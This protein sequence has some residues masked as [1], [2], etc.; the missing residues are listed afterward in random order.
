VIHKFRSSPTTLSDR[1]PFH[2]ALMTDGLTRGLHWD[3]NAGHGDGLMGEARDRVVM[4]TGTGSTRGWAG[5]VDS[6]RHKHS[7]SAREWPGVLDPA[8]GSGSNDEGA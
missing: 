4:Y 6:G 1:P 2:L 3:P 8:S 7:A 5:W